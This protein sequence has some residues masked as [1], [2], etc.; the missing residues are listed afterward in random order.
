[1]KIRDPSSP[2]NKVSILTLLLRRSAT[3]EELF[4]LSGL[5]PPSYQK[6]KKAVWEI[7]KQYLGVRLSD[8][9]HEVLRLGPRVGL[10]W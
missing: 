10:G 5:F 9:K 1:M 3:L 4:H 7:S 6:N 8:R 2:G